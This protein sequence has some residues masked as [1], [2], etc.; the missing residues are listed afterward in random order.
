M[1]RTYVNDVDVVMRNEKEGWL[2]LKRRRMKRRKGGLRR[3][4]DCPR[5]HGDRTYMHLLAKSSTSIIEKKVYEH[6]PQPRR[7]TTYLIAAM[8]VE[9]DDLSPGICDHLHVAFDFVSFRIATVTCSELH[10]LFYHGLGDGV[11]R[12]LLPICDVRD[13]RILAATAHPSTSSLILCHIGLCWPQP[14]RPMLLKP[15]RADASQRTLLR[16]SSIRT[17]LWRCSS[18]RIGLENNSEV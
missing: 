3:A 7:T 11:H 15:R 18:E 6:Q 10:P 1:K 14:R 12:L 4:V 17:Q 9:G 2:S 16:P 5:E 13:I 8:L